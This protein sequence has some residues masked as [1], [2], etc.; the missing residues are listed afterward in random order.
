M[1]QAFDK[2]GAILGEMYGQTKR[3]VFDKLT[4]VY[5]DAHEYR[6][7]S[8][9][10]QHLGATEDPGRVGAVEEADTATADPLADASEQSDSG[11]HT[12]PSE[13]EAA[14]QDEGSETS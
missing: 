7:K 2:D 13:A 1:G 8:M 6:I 9:R 11:E 10:D 5:P 3:E 14:A 12:P 4:N